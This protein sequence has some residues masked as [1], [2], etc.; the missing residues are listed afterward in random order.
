MN[1][2]DD[3]KLI[4]TLTRIEMKLDNL[5]KTYQEHLADH[6]DHETRIRSLEKKIWSLPSAA[7]ILNAVGAVI[8]YWVGSK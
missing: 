8:A 7:F 6:S 2:L 1:P 3:P 5:A 4:E